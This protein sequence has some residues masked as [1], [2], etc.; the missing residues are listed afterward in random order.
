M[1]MCPVVLCA[2]DKNETCIDRNILGRF[3]GFFCTTITESISVYP[4]IELKQQGVK[5]APM[6]GRTFY[7]I[8]STLAKPS[9]PGGC[10][11]GRHSNEQWKCP[12]SL[13]MRSQDVGIYT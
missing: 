11:V 2:F 1:F 3:V 7:F 6:H 13:H 8:I 4:R 5:C 9:L 12:S 10:C